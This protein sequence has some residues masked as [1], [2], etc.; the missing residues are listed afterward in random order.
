MSR[1]SR[2][3]KTKG[4]KG[5][6]GTEGTATT[7]SSTVVEEAYGPP[8]GIVV[9]VAIVLSIPA[10]LQFVDGTMAFDSAAIRFLAALAVSWI[11]IHLV[12]TVASSFSQQTTTTKTTS[13]DSAPGYLNDPNAQ[14]RLSSPPEDGQR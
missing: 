2:P 1:K 5:K 10:L 12:Y 6:K 8:F 14:F 3:P 9:L 7:Q 11:L 4:R 13:M